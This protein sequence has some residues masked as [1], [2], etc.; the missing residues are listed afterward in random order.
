MTAVAYSAFSDH[1]LQGYCSAAFIPKS[2][3]RVLEWLVNIVIK[4][5]ILSIYL[6]A[7]G[8]M[9]GHYDQQCT[10]LFLSDLD[11]SCPPWAIVSIGMLKISSLDS[12]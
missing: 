4:V 2:N 9:E 3:F 7:G 6:A 5:N 10:S 11:V 8:I 1:I 12:A